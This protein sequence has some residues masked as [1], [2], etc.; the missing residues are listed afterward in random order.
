MDLFG[1][2][3]KVVLK[4]TLRLKVHLHRERGAQNLVLDF[5]NTF[6]VPWTVALPLHC[7]KKDPEVVSPGILT[8]VVFPVIG[9]CAGY[10]GYAIGFAVA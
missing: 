7:S 8:A 5:G 9:F 2:P 3:L 1:T 6:G 4:E 10:I